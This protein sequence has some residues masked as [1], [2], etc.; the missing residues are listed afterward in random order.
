MKTLHNNTFDGTFQL[1]FR[2]IPPHF[3]PMLPFDSS[4]N[5]KK[6]KDL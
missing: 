3:F 2:Y 5:I 1:S 6:L 4:E